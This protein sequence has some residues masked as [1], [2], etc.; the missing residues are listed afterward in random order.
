MGI[1]FTFRPTTDLREKLIKV[2]DSLLSSWQKF[3]VFRAHFL[4]SLSHHLESGRVQR[5]FLNELNTR[6]VEFLRQVSYVPHTTHTAFLFADHWAGGLGASQLKK[7]ADVWTV[8]RSVHC[9][10]AKTKSS[11]S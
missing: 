3:E 6:C 2:A 5:G 10:T 9:W 11:A 7:D 4:P 8:A 1:R